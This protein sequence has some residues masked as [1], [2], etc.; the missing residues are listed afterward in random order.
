MSEFLDAYFERCAKP[1]GLRSIGS[2]RSQIGVLKEH[3][4]NL[5]IA[6]LEDADEINRF[7]ADSE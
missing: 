3:L 1:A 2:V 7:K 4:G 6:A 5:P